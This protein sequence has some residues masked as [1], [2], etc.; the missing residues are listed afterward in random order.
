MANA[1]PQG[2]DG[3]VIERVVLSF[4]DA[5]QLAAAIR[6]AQIEHRQLESGAFSGELRGVI[7]GSIV[8]NSGRYSRTLRARGCLPADAVVIGA[9]L[10]AERDGC[11]N[12]FRCGARDLICYPPGAELDYL[13]PA[14]TH[15]AAL[16]VPRALLGELG[17]PPSLFARPRVFSA[18]LPGCARIVS[19]IARLAG[20]GARVSLRDWEAEVATLADELAPLALQRGGLHARPNYAERMR[21]LRSFE[22]QVNERIGE[23]LR[24]PALCDAIGVAQRTL[25]QTFRDQLGVSPKRYL[26]ILRLHAARDALLRGAATH[27]GTLAAGCGIPHA[28]RFASDYRKLFGEAPS[29]TGRG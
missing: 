6:E 10:E 27:I 5:E 14:R 19:R 7:G 23:S 8:L 24:I 29:A 9:I 2:T 13:L 1:T 21:Q 26:T 22:Q 12:G 16:Q 25:E 20:A 4:F 11:I 18:S 17:L 28:G 3:P 15:W